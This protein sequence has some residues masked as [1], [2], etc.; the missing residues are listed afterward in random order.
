MDRRQRLLAALLAL[1]AAGAAAA[2]TSCIS[3]PG[4]DSAQQP[5]A[6][7]DDAAVIV[8]TPVRGGR[9][10]LWTDPAETSCWHLTVVPKSGESNTVRTCG[11]GTTPQATRLYGVIVV[12]NGCAAGEALVRTAPDA[13]PVRY[14]AKSS[15]FLMAQPVSGEIG[16]SFDLACAATPDTF[17]PILVTGA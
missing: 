7:P 15:L 5:Q 1:T 9:M 4:S 17:H 2:F 11:D 16:E 12:L 3:V 14:V 8:E 6:V 13:E 10:L